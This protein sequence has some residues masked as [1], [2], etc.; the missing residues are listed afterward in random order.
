MTERDLDIDFDFFEEEPPTEESSRTQRIIRRPGGPRGP[1]PPRAPQNLT[2]LLRLVG[3]IAFAI[4][5][6]V[7]LVFW[8]QSCQEAGKTKTYK[9][10]MSKVSD[11]AS[12]SQQIGRQLSQA[13]LT[14]A[15]RPQLQQKISG[16]ARQEQQDVEQARGITPPGPLR[17]E[18]QAVVQALQ[19]RVSGLTGLSNAIGAIGSIKNTTRGAGLLAAQM[20]RLLAGDVI[21]EDSFRAP[22]V[23][24]LQRQGVTGTNDAGG[25]LVPSSKFLQNAELAT[26]STMT[27]IVARL[28]GASTAGQGCPCGTG[29]VSTKVLPSGRELS[30]TTQTSIVVTTDMS[31]E[32][33]VENSGNSQVFS[34]PVK[35][36]IQQPKGGNITKTA[37][38]DFL[39]P[40][41]QTK[42]TFR[43][44]PTVNFTSPETIK[45]EVQPVAGEQNQTNNSADY[46]VIFSVA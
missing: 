27:P 44:F 13:L 24:E 10:Y 1:A 4:L 18:Q 40:G 20:Q 26:T 14:P 43:N 35:L 31:F 39:N 45:V 12:A 41:D 8:I 23:A 46:P 16:L 7:L 34:I 25:P 32:V 19:F 9:S 29:L 5:I 17:E 33:T 30:T 11:V 36:T 2:P 38:I 3:L 22:S 37:R 21:W 28:R 15:K 42:V 6:I